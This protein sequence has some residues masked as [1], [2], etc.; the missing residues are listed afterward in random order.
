MTLGARIREAR[1]REGLTQLELA[2]QISSDPNLVSRWERD[3]SEPSLRNLLHLSV[4]LKVGPAE[5]MD[6]NDDG[7]KAA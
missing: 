2:R 1:Q 6:G 5:L 4:V 3:Q 7:G